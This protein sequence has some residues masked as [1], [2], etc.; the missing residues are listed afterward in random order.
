MR[1][2]DWLSWYQRQDFYNR[3]AQECIEDWISNKRLNEDYVNERTAD[4]RATIALQRA[5]YEV[6]RMSR[7]T[8]ENRLAPL[9]AWSRRMECSTP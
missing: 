2:E 9:S 8:T 5:K 3:I 7:P 1:S 4:D 6:A